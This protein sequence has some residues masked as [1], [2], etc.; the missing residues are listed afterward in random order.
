MLGQ[1]STFSGRARKKSSVLTGAH[2]LQSGR[3]DASELPQT[4]T[5]R[6]SGA[7]SGRTQH[8]RWD[9]R[10]DRRM[11]AGAAY[12]SRARC[13]PVTGSVVCVTLASAP[14][15]A[16]Q[17]SVSRSPRRRPHKTLSCG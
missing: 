3:G 9:A 10:A 6:G 7:R 5:G 14:S 16:L 4:G 11:L 13:Q 1:H 8:V 17:V 12:A 15:C 2:M